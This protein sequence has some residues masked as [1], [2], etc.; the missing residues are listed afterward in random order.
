MKFCP[1]WVHYNNSR[2]DFGLCIHSFDP[3]YIL[4]PYPNTVPD[5]IDIIHYH[6]CFCYTG[7]IC[8]FNQFWVILANNL[9]I[10]L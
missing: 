8:W 6:F 5:N 7:N 1:Y 3:F 9:K 2:I 10:M 4:N